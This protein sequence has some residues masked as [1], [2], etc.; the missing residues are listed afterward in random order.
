[1]CFLKSHL[2]FHTNNWTYLINCLGDTLESILFN[3]S[4]FCPFP[5]EKD[6]ENKRPSMAQVSQDQGAV[7]IADPDEDSP[8]MIAYRK[9][10][11][12]CL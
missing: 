11:L 4:L 9:V 5:T 7:G 3:W 1:M 8:N 2:Y 10:L 12:H 6:R